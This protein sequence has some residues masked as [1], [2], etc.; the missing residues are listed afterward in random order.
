ME[1]E[2]TKQQEKVRKM[3]ENKAARL[4]QIEGKE[5]LKQKTDRSDSSS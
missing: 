2:T 3:L 4:Q 5:E 1:I